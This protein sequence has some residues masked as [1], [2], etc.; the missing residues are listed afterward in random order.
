[1]TLA[2]VLD[3]R[4]RLVRISSYLTEYYREMSDLDHGLESGQRA[5]K[6][7]AT[8]GDIGLEVSAH[9]S[10]GLIYYDLGDYRQAVDCLGWHRAS[11]TDDLRREHFGMSGLPF[12]LSGS[13]MCWSL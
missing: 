10:L 8:L 9:F 12:V 1:E 11:L 6:L 3:D 2:Q 7:A 13:R 5:L 4:Q